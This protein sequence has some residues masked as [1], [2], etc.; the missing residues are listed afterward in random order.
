MTGDA[1]PDR[2]AHRALPGRLLHAHARGSIA[3]AR[4]HLPGPRPALPVPRRP[5]HASASMARAGGPER[6]AGVRPR[7]L[8]AADVSVRDLAGIARPTP[9]FLRLACSYW[10]TGLA[11][12][13][14]DLSQ[15]RVPGR[16]SSGYVPELRRD[17][18]S[19]GPS[20]V[21]AQA[22]ARDGSL[23][24][25]FLLGGTDRVLHVV[26]APSPAATSRSRSAGCSPRR[27][28]PG[29]R[30]E[31]RVGRAHMTSTIGTTI[32]RGGR[33]GPGASHA[34]YAV[35]TQ[36]GSQGASEDMT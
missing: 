36:V 35:A 1:T 31:A 3:G 8:P 26:N 16:G 20:G 14:R 12:M 19:F 10:R 15:A 18:L 33:A 24:D 11:E 13:W 22:L 9:G 27:R 32:G 25:D 5:P 17:Q 4:A 6:R 28:R 29:S 7:G 30:C 34:L 2:A 21:R 23:V